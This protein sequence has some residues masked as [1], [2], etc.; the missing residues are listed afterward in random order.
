MGFGRLNRSP[1]GL[2]TREWLSSRA[3]GLTIY[4]LKVSTRSWGRMNWTCL[5]KVWI[6]KKNSDPGVQVTGGVQ[7]HRKNF[8]WVRVPVLGGRGA[9]GRGLD[10]ELLLV[11]VGRNSGP[12]RPHSHPVSRAKRIIQVCINV[13]F[14]CFP[15]F[16]CLWN[17]ITPTSPTNV[18]NFSSGTPL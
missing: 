17:F 7:G 13:M 16:V 8:V 3:V 2:R 15:L 9:E 4:S 6:T 10:R 5:M 1:D 11:G 12:W 14:P 18:R